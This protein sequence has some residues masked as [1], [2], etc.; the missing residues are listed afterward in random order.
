MK[1]I[2][3]L[4]ESNDNN[5]LSVDQKEDISKYIELPLDQMTIIKLDDNDKLIDILRDKPYNL[6]NY[7]QTHGIITLAKVGGYLVA[8]YRDGTPHS[9]VGDYFIA[10]S[11]GG[12]GAALRLLSH[13]DIVA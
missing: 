10:S 9:Y 13:N 5:L 11:R 12:I 3:I 1:L 2:N 8:V 4:L 6:T 7:R